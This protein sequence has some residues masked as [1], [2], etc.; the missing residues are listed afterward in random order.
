MFI[1]FFLLT[2]NKYLSGHFLSLSYKMSL[3]RVLHSM[4]FFLLRVLVLKGKMWSTCLSYFIVEYWLA[5]VENFVENKVYTPNLLGGFPMQ[6]YY[7]FKK[8]SFVTHCAFFIG[9]IRQF[10]ISLWSVI[11]QNNSVLIPHYVW[12]SVHMHDSKY[13]PLREWLERQY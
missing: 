8:E 5:S 9:N 12:Y 7:L 6:N 4:L 10:H 2:L 1:Y 11:G 3:C 13:I